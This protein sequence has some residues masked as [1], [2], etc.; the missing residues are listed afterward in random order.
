[1]HHLCNNVM[2]AFWCFSTVV[3]KKRNKKT[4][5]I[6]QPFPYFYFFS[7][8]P[9]GLLWHLRLSSL[10][11]LVWKCARLPS[12]V[13]AQRFPSSV[14][15]RV[16]SHSLLLAAET[17]RFNGM[18]WMWRVIDTYIKLTLMIASSTKCGIWA[19][20]K[21]FQ[22][23]PV[24]WKRQDIGFVG[25]LSTNQPEA[26]FSLYASRGGGAIHCLLRW[27]LHLQTFCFSLFY[28]FL[29]TSVIV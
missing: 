3:R 7:S 25:I 14:F 5:E 27:C 11:L 24:R 28:L 16:S 10:T 13:I 8:L 26:F 12:Y 6:M 2:K 22:V 20:S 9:D 29:F 17:I 21:R 4:G 23:K 18:K 1:M 19:I 15:F